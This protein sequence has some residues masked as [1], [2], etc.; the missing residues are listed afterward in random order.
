[1]NAT[2]TVAG[3][4]LTATA[5]LAEP[6]VI[7][8]MDDK[9]A[10][11]TE[12]DGL[13]VLSVSASGSDEVEMLSGAGVGIVAVADGPDSQA[14]FGAP[15]IVAE[16]TGTQTCDEGDALDY[17]VI[18]LG[19]VPDDPQR[20]LT[21]CGRLTVVAQGGVITFAPEPGSADATTWTWA[22]ATGFQAK[23]D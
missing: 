13:E 2:R 22:A 23:A 20:P 8:L 14:L 10:T 7:R 3:F 15:L 19:P 5:A 11:I 6:Q 12:V 18:R 9:A 21:S 1:M 16:V 4:L 17:F